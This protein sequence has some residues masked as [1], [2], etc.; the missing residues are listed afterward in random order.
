M[1]ITRVFRVDIDADLSAEFEEKFAAVSV[2]VAESADG[3]IS[4]TILRPTSWAPNEYAMISVWQDEDS[5]Q[6]FAG[7]HWNQAVIPEGMEKFVKT[8]SVHHYESWS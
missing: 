1:A 3:N 6:S 4:V 7:E 8:C 5:L 2:H